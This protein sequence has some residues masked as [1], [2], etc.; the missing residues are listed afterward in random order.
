MASERARRPLL[1]PGFRGYPTG[2]FELVD[3]DS[4]WMGSKVIIDVEVLPPY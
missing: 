4:M 3:G 2:R 1:D